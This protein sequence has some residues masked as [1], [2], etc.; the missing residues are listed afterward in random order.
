MISNLLYVRNILSIL[1]SFG[2]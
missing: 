2:G 1:L